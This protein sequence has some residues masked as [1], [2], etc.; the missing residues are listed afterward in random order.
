MPSEIRYCEQLEYRVEEKPDV[1]VTT[2]VFPAMLAR[3]VSPTG[4]L[5]GF[6]RTYLTTE[7]HKA[8]V[9]EPRKMLSAFQGA[10]KG[11]AIRL[12]P[13][14]TVLG[15]AEGI[16]TALACH[17]ATDLPVWS[18]ISAGGLASLVVPDAVQELVI[19]ADNDKSE[20]G[21]KAARTLARRM[22]AE[23]CKVKIIKPQTV[24]TDWADY[25]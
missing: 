23:D 14:G 20:T 6:H 7:G 12:Y 3:I 22:L 13:A 25:A 9:Q 1:W 16:E 21:E 4:E 11:A 18:T 17:V 19:F 24:E 10:T 15:V 2:G 5:A 8:P